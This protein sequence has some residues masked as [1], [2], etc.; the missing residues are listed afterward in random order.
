MAL[1][2]AQLVELKDNRVQKGKIEGKLKFDENASLL[3]DWR[4]V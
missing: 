1:K 4:E 3:S 2:S